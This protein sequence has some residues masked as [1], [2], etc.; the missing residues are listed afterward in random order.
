MPR[1]IVMTNVIALLCLSVLLGSSLTRSVDGNAPVS[2]IAGT[3]LLSIA[4]ATVVIMGI[5]EWFTGIRWVPVV[6]LGALIL[7]GVIGWASPL[8]HTISVIS[9]CAAWAAVAYWF[10]RLSFQSRENR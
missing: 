9:V 8:T 6:A 7:V 5:T 4:V 10:G 2:G 3:V 1:L